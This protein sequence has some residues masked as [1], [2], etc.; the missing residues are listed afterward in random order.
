MT[1]SRQ[2]RQER[3]ERPIDAEIDMITTR[4]SKRRDGPRLGLHPFGIQVQNIKE[5]PRLQ[6]WIAGIRALSAK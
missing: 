5:F 2:K 6:K 3:Q 1:A 4:S